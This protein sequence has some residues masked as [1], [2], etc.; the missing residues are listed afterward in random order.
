VLAPDLP[1]PGDAAHYRDVAQHLA[2]GDGFVH[3]APGGGPLEPWAEHTPLFPVVLAGLDLVG[4]TSLRAHA[5]VLAL[6]SGAGVALVA[7]LGRRVAGPG[8]GLVAA[9]IAALHPMWVQPAGLVL[10]ESLHLVLVP[11]VLLAALDLRER[12]TPLAAIWLGLA[13]AAAGLNRPEALGLLVVVAAPAV[14]LGHLRSWA[15]WRTLGVVA[16]VTLLGILP[17]VARNRVEYDAWVLST[18]GGKTLYGSTCPDTFSGPSLGG[19]SY[20]CQFGAANVFIE[21][22]PPEG[23]HWHAREFDDAFAEAARRYLDDHRD[24]VP[25]VV[26]ARVARLWGVAFLEDQRRFDEVEGRHPGLQHLGQWIHIGLL[27]LAVVGAAL[28]LRDRR[29]RDAAIVL[30]GPVILVTLTCLLIYGGSR[31]RTGA[32]AS[33]AVFAA[34]S[35]VAISGRGTPRR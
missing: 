2:D 18:N 10:S 8:V 27:V 12:R 20:D 23:T 6:V 7:W 34:A 29:R 4:L 21:A 32:E 22:G 5:V 33:L 17:W 30:L 19:F 3:P 31:M 25:K 11:L 1:V 14:L 28:L 26:A 9:A 16:L 24:E 35:I 15:A 13:I